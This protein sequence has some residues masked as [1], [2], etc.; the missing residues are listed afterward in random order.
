MKIRNSIYLF[1]PLL[2]LF[3]LNMVSCKKKGEDEGIWLTE[4]IK[5]YFMFKEGTRWIYHEVNADLYDTVTVLKS[6]YKIYPPCNDLCIMTTR[7]N[8]D[9]DSYSSYRKLSLSDT[10]IWWTSSF[11]EGSGSHN[12]RMLYADLDSSLDYNN[13]DSLIGHEYLFVSPLKAGVKLGMRE[14]NSEIVTIDTVITVEGIEYQDV[15]KVMVTNNPIENNQETVYFFAKNY[16]LIEKLII[17]SNQRWELIE[18][19]I[20]Q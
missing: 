13:S 10:P 9:V 12:Q 5:E 4:E 11:P 18:S 15:V 14:F 17:D 2:L 8:Y 7:D 16:G 1:L 20:L 6:E 19:I 3:I